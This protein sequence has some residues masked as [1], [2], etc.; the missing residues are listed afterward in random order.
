MDKEESENTKTPSSEWEQTIQYNYYY[1]I[2]I[3]TENVHSIRLIITTTHRS[4]KQII[5]TTTLIRYSCQ[6]ISNGQ[7]VDSWKH[8]EHQTNW[9]SSQEFLQTTDMELLQKIPQQKW[10]ND[11][12]QQRRI[13]TLNRNNKRTMI[14]RRIHL[15]RKVNNTYKINNYNL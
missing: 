15:R 4:Q 11:K 1:T 9:Y 7:H 2:T 12:R 3:C 13:E 8:K 6:D 10:T 5:T 14:I